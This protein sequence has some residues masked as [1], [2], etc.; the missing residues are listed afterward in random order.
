MGPLVR[1]NCAAIPETLLESELFGYEEGA[2]T[3]ASRK[4]KKGKFELADHGTILLDEIGD[5]P[6]SIQAKLLRVLQEKE[7]ERVGGTHPVPVDVRL[8]SSTNRDLLDLVKQGQFRE[9]LFY[10]INVVTLRIPPL[11]ERLDDLALI[12]KTILQ[13]LSD[14]MGMRV[15]SIEEKVWE[16][17]YNHSWP[18]NIRE[19]RNVLERAMHLMEDETLKPEHITLPQVD[20]EDRSEIMTLKQTVQLAEI[21]AIEKTLRVT[22]GDR[23]AAAK[24]LGISKSS[25]YQKL[26]EYQSHLPPSKLTL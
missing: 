13:Q 15:R 22:H 6:L 19:L 24:L 12:V 26:A 7:I 23:Q 5:M 10:R 17:L 11:R 8:L 20:K 16:K 4:G 2:F 18:G 9:D 1:V 25:L 14:S 3:G 21:Q